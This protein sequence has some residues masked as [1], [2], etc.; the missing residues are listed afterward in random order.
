VQCGTEAARTRYAAVIDSRFPL[1]RV[2]EAF[3][4]LESKRASGKIV[5]DVT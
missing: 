3:A 5:V 2:Q 4:V 1:E